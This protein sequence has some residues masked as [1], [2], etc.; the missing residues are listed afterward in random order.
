MLS[1]VSISEVPIY[2][3][4]AKQNIPVAVAFFLFEFY[5]GCDG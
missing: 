1:L 3:K 4:F 5:P 2:K